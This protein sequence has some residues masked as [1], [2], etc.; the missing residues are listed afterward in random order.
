MIRRK[1]KAPIFYQLPNGMPAILYPR[2]GRPPEVAPG[3]NRHHIPA[4]TTETS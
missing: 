2:Q 4:A 3:G 1:L